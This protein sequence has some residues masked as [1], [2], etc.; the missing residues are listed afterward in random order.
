M[1]PIELR[2]LVVQLHPHIE[3]IVLSNVDENV[4]EAEILDE[5]AA[6]VGNRY[7]YPIAAIRSACTG[8]IPFNPER[9]SIGGVTIA[10]SVTRE[11]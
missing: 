4:T 1:E 2:R 11:R 9:P 6:V 3:N 10:H 5:Y 7:R 8:L